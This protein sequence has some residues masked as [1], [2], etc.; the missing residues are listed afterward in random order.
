[1][2]IQ[3]R[4]F[5]C[6]ASLLKLWSCSSYS[7]PAREDKVLEALEMSCR[8][9]CLFASTLQSSSMLWS[10]HMIKTVYEY[11]QNAITMAALKNHNQTIVTCTGWYRGYPTFVVSI[12]MI[13]LCT[14]VI[15]DVAGH[16][17]C[18]IYLKDTVNAIA[19][20]AL[21]TSV[22]G[23]SKHNKLLLH[24][25]DFLCHFLRNYFLLWVPHCLLMELGPWSHSSEALLD[26][27]VAWACMFN[28]A[29][30]Y[31]ISSSFLSAF[32]CMYHIKNGS[33]LLFFF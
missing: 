32:L 28:V 17:G 11:L 8:Q 21:G 2:Q 12:A 3:W 10:R 16:L 15:G 7:R 1:M 31:M 4:S 25:L 27:S 30:I 26:F 13:G 5:F 33:G 20:V 14:A 22:P 6:T 9:F 24:P 23:T 18:F 19:F 29:M